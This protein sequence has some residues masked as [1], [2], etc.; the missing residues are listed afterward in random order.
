MIPRGVEIFVALDPIEAMSRALLN[1]GDG[2]M[3]SSRP[4]VVMQ[5]W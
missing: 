4:S 3:I 2:R 1:F 5:Q